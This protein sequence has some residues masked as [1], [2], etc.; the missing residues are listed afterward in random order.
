VQDV[1]YAELRSQLEKD[2][3]VLAYQAPAK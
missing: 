1:P 3:Q 2:G